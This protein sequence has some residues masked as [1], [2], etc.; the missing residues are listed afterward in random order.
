MSTI[1]WFVKGA[2]LT[3]ARATA[4]S[5]TGAAETVMATVNEGDKFASWL[6]NGEDARHAAT[7]ATMR[8]NC[9]ITGQGSTIV[10]LKQRQKRQ[11]AL[12]ENNRDQAS[13]YEMAFTSSV[14]E[15]D[16]TS[17]SPLLAIALFRL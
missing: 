16:P 3:G 13:F 5:A 11:A 10:C 4:T 15:T 7:K 8:L 12:G 17:K 1:L 6:S 2:R 14:P 9:M